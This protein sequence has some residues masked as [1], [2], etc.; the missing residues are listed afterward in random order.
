M[1]LGNNFYFGL[2]TVNKTSLETVLRFVF[3]KCLRLFLINKA[4]FSK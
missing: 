4:V 1:N 3:T 2:H